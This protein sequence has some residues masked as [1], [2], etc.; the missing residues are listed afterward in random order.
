MSFDIITVRKREK[1][2]LGGGGNSQLTN[3]IRAHANF[4]EYSLLA[5]LLLFILEMQNFISIAIYI[6][7]V[8]L[9]SA[10]G[11]LAIS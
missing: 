10:G 6:A 1:L 4:I 9:F 3:A 2:G 7:G 5:V 8:S 11:P